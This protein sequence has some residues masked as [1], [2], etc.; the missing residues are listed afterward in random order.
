M[1]DEKV[2]E[3]RL[4]R[5]ADRQGLR[6]AKSRRRDERALDYGCYGLITLEGNVSVFEPVGSSIHVATLDEV[7]SYLYGVDEHL[8]NAGV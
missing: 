8:D 2:R 5:V 4:R 1:T 3:N 7:S 6:L